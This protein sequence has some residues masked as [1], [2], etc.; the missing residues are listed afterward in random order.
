M[1]FTYEDSDSGSAFAETEEQAN[2]RIQEA[3]HQARHA[4][5]DEA[6]NTKPIEAERTIE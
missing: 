6:A 3:D 2:I 1:S 5:A 4:A